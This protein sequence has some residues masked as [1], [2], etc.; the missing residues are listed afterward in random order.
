M[1]LQDKGAKFAFSLVLLGGLLG[2]IG[3][4]LTQGSAQIPLG[5]V[6]ETIG[7]RLLG[8]EVDT[9]TAIILFSIRL[10]RIILAALVGGALAGAGVV[11]QGLFQNPMAEPYVMGISSGAALGATIALVGPLNLAWLGLWA[12]PSMAFLGGLVT[13]LLVLA[14][15]RL[16]IDSAMTALLLAGIAI[17]SFMSALN[18]LLMVFNQ[19][20]IQQIIFWLMGGF[21][22]R[23][24]EHVLAILPHLSI[25]FFVLFLYVEH[26]NILSL[27]PERA[28]HLGVDI[29]RVQLI[30]IIGASLITAAAVSVSGIIGFVGLIIPHTIRILMGPEHKALLPASIIA[31]AMFL[32][33]ADTAARVFFS[34]MELP[35]GVITALAGAPFFLYL[36]HKGKQTLG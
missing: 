15:G 20:D 12:V 33:L 27:G 2:A 5:K 14:L 22:G 36:L 26:L 10:P 1:W 31:G 34:P 3:L 7:G 35:V 29:G 30:L 6:L 4:A 11:F 8:G 28:V 9:T 16:G 18:S 25:G 23:G 19:Q 32:V 13:T 17:G 24:W 21:A